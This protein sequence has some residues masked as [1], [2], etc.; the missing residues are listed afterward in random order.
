MANCG[1]IKVI[2]R[3]GGVKVENVELR[4]KK[5]SISCRIIAAQM[6]VHENT[7]H[8]WLNDANLDEVKK[9]RLLI[10]IEEIKGVK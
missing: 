7:V 3:R 6:G 9:Q 8:N 2:V 5:G 4:V 10:A 1:K